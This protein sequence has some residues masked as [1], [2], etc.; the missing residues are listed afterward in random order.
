MTDNQIALTVLAVFT[1][2][3]AVALGWREWRVRR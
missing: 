3:L 2:Y 1:V